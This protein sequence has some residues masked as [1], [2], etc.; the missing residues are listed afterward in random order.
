MLLPYEPISYT[1]SEWII[2]KLSGNETLAKK[3]LIDLKAKVEQGKKQFVFFYA[4]EL[5]TNLVEEK[6]EGKD[7]VRLLTY[8]K[9]V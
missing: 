6:L 2:A 4:E 9:L 3:E 7:Y 1:R 5:M 8:K